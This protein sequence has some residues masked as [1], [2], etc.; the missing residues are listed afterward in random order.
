RSRLASSARA[1]ATAARHHRNRKAAALATRASSLDGLSPLSVLGRGYAVARRPGDGAI[2]R[3]A[4]QVAAGEPIDVR[5]AEARI[6]A[7]VESV[8]DLSDR[9]K[10]LQN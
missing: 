8:E 4:D 9:E 2:L 10:T 3:R 1:L 5:L 7:R 6:E